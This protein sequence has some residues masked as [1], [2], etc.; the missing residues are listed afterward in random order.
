MKTYTQEITL[1]TITCG[2]CAGTMALNARWLECKRKES[3]GYTCPYCNQQRGWWKS[4]AEKL[5]EELDRKSNELTSAKSE[6]LRLT[7]QRDEEIKARLEAERKLKR[8][9]KGV[10]PC[11]NRTF[12]NLARHMAVKHKTAKVDA[13]GNLQ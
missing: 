7:H 3:G 4:E 8:V 6:A 11:C 2:S 12:K 1:E 5:R 13:K 9:D 10:C